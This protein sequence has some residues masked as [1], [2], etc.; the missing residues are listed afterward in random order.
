MTSPS[1]L[2][3]KKIFQRIDFDHFY[4][5]TFFNSKGGLQ[6]SHAHGKA[7]S[8]SLHTL[9]AAVPQAAENWEVEGNGEHVYRAALWP[10]PAP[11]SGAPTRRPRRAGRHGTWRPEARSPEQ[12]VLGAPKHAARSSGCSAP[13]SARPGAV[14]ARRLLAAHFM[15]CLTHLSLHSSK[16]LPFI[17]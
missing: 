15:F 6:A 7:F 9:R 4:A 17:L 8:P 11:G 13:R 16:H 2:Q 12:W 10:F 14:G 3:K 5:D 1:H